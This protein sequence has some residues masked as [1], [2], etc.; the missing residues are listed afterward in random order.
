MFLYISVY[1]HCHIDW[2]M[3]HEYL[4][5]IANITKRLL[6]KNESRERLAN[7]WYVNT[8]IAHVG[9]LHRVPSLKE[10]S[11]VVIPRS[12]DNGGMIEIHLRYHRCHSSEFVKPRPITKPRQMCVQMKARQLYVQS[13]ARRLCVQTKS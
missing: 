3:V 6:H 12:V 7:C 10:E 11:L 5:L 1:I 13:K 8:L 9:V 4:F 2:C